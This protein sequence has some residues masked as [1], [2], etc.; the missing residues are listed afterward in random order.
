MEIGP[1]D[2]DSG[3][4][5]SAGEV[6]VVE[7]DPHRARTWRDLLEFSDYKP[8]VIGHQQALKPLQ[9][10]WVAAMVGQTDCK[11]TL[12]G[13]LQQLHN[14]DA[15]LPVFTLG[16]WSDRFGT[17]AEHPCLQLSL[18][19]K[20]PTLVSALSRARRRYQGP[21]G[22]PCG[23]SAV[24][25]ELERLMNQV[26]GYDS[27]VLI[28]GESGVGKEL[29]AQYI[30][31]H[32]PR[33]AGPFVPVNCGAIPRDLLE[34]ELFGHRKGAFTGA[35]ADRVGRFEL[36]HGGTLFLDEIG[37][38]SPDMQ[39][40][41]LRVLQ[42][43]RF[44][45][46]GD[47]QSRH[48]DVRILAATHRDLDAAVKVNEF[49]QD[50]FFRLA[51]FPL[52]VPALRERGDD[53]LDLIEDINALNASQ[54][55]PTCSLSAGALHEL[56]RYPWPG[57]VRELS[58][59]M[60]RLAI[61]FPGQVVDAEDLPPQYR[62]TGSQLSFSTDDLAQFPSRGMDLREHLSAIEQ[63]LIRG[64]MNE[65]DGTV[66]QAARLLNLRRTTLVEK[67][68]RYSLHL[69]TSSAELQAS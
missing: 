39:V 57:N 30:H 15:Q 69:E 24:V 28:L 33:A 13:L 36:A 68:R 16:D 11:K 23:Q 12:R 53:L 21:G 29:V 61:L 45:R 10:D 42:E 25:G 6:L 40:K 19:I 44:E 51:V 2:V 32:S 38:M 41:L 64:A 5:M 47:T 17:V 4:A 49:R 66:A 60:E 65:A 22:F 7:S 3:A 8:V 37:D 31:A 59:L 26:A 56:V 67:L 18:P 50:L 27:S 54:G 35:I 14:H 62:H 43:H 9:G 58:N 48:A 52:T 20:Y 34:S 1:Q 46:V 63:Q 55:K